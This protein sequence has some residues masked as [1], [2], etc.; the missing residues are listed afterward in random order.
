MNYVEKL[1]LIKRS[2]KKYLWEELGV[3]S[4]TGRI[5][6]N[7][8]RNNIV[9]S[10]EYRGVIEQIIDTVYLERPIVRSVQEIEFQPKG[11]LVRLTGKNVKIAYVDIVSIH[12]SMHEGTD[13]YY[14]NDIV[15]MINNAKEQVMR[16]Y[17]EESVDL[18]LLIAKYL[19]K[20]NK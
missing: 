16:I 10:D 17:D 9:L 19:L 13:K 3:C 4:A 5:T 18:K 20:K 1:E 11:I 2:D 15:Y 6:L 14:P 8:Y 7:R 12:V